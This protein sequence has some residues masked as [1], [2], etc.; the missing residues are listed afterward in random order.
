MISLPNVAAVAR[1]T[2]DPAGLESSEEWDQDPGSWD[3]DNT[4]WTQTVF[5]PTNDSLMMFQPDGPK[6]LANDRGASAD[7]QAIQS[8]LERLSMRVGEG[9]YHSVITQIAPQI[10][11]ETGT[12]VD[13]RM[14]YQN[15]FGDP[16]TWLPTTPFYV[17]QSRAISQIID[18]R[19]LSIQF[20]FD[21]ETDWRMHGYYLKIKEGGEY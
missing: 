1:G 7:G 9:I 20:N 10:E 3:L 15:Y 17:G 19:Y 2:I 18:G 6:L 21:T 14:G 13:I 4:I 8:T 16:I 11:G 5:S 12:Q